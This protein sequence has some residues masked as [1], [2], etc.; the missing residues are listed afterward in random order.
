MGAELEEHHRWWSRLTE[1]C[2]GCFNG[3]VL[4]VFGGWFSGQW[5]EG[6]AVDHGEEVD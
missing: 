1:T 4:M 3:I 2:C 6:L 5:S